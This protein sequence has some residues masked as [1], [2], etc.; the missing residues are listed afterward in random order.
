MKGFKKICGQ[1]EEI[2]IRNKNGELIHLLPGESW[3]CAEDAPAC[4]F[5]KK[6][7]MIIPVGMAKDEQL[8]H[9]GGYCMLRCRLGLPHRFMVLHEKELMEGKET[10]RI[11]GD[12][13]RIILMEEMEETVRT[14]GEYL[15]MNKQREMWERIETKIKGSFLREGWI[16]E[17]CRPGNFQLRKRGE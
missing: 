7:E 5:P 16:Q 13:A 6:Q 2:F 10:E 1:E 17:E 9:W 15:D 11:L 12:I 3:D 14:A 4:V 8:L